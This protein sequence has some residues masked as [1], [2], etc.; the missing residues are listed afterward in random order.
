MAIC[1]HLDQIQ[2]VQ[3]RTPEGCE[4]CLA[5]GGRWV[6]L[7][8]CLACGHIGCCDSSPGRHASRHYTA[9]GHPIARSFEPGEEWAWCFV[10]EVLFDPAPKPA[11]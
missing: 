8:E 1:T 10:D 6:H 7:R 5:T 2:N 4:E 3:P 11:I 9:T